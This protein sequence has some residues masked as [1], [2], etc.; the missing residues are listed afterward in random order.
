MHRFYFT[1]LLL[2]VSLSMGCAIAFRP[3]PQLI[4]TTI[5]R[6]SSL[7]E[8]IMFED[9]LLDPDPPAGSLIYRTEGNPAFLQRQGAPHS[10]L[11]VHGGAVGYIHP[12]QYDHALL[13]LK[14]LV[15]SGAPPHR[16]RP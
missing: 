9:N 4:A 2:T 13:R 11:T 12:A 3:A 8:T 15:T 1:L 10:Q 5:E 16:H 7:C 6:P 14:L